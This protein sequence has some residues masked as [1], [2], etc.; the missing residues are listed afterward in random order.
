MSTPFARCE[1]SHIRGFGVDTV[2]WGCYYFFRRNDMKDIGYKIY[3]M[4]LSLAIVSGNMMLF[5]FWWGFL[6]AFITI[7]VYLW[8]ADWVV[9][10]IMR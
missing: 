8:V 3:A 6:G 7:H 9:Y 2:G 5:G 1:K 10:R 4:V